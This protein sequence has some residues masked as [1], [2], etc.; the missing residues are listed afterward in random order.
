MLWWYLGPTIADRRKLRARTDGP[1][2]YLL[3]GP[4]H[5]DASADKSGR[6]GTCRD[7]YDPLFKPETV[8]KLSDCGV[9]LIDSSTDVVPFALK[10]LGL[11]PTSQSPGDLKKAEALLVGIRPY[12][13]DINSSPIINDLADGTICIALGWSGD[14]VAARNRAAE[15]GNGINVAYLL[16]KEGSLVWMATLAIPTDAPHPEAAHA[17]IN[18]LLDPKVAAAMVSNTGF[19]DAVP[20]SRQYLPPAIAEDRSVMSFAAPSRILN[21]PDAA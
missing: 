4:W 5:H 7:S 12:L 18:H 1:A 6:V 10:Y 16:P 21:D 9:A 13:K 17:F 8:S 11:G 14:I 15:A 19:A 20:A 3:I 2:N